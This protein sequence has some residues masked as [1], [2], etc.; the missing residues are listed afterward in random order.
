ML[1]SATPSFVCPRSWLGIV[2]RQEDLNRPGGPRPAGADQDPPSNG[3]APQAARSNSIVE[4][5]AVG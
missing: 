3:A 1:C 5:S 2:P 4:M